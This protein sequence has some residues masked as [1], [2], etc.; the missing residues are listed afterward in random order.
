MKKLTS[1]MT[2]LLALFAF[3][4]VGCS[5]DDDDDDDDATSSSSE[6]SAESTAETEALA[7]F[8]SLEGSYVELFPVIFDSAYYDMWVSYLTPYTG[9]TY[10]DTVYETMV[11]WMTGELYGEEAIEAYSTGTAYWNCSF[12][13]QFAKLTFSYDSLKISA[14]DEDG[15]E[16]FS[17]KYSYY[18]EA[19]D[20]YGKYVF[21][22]ED[23]A[24]EFKYFIFAGDTPESTYHI[25][26]R[27]GSDPQALSEFYTGAYAYWNAAG[28]PED[29]DDELLDNVIKLFADENGEYVMSALGLL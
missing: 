22:T 19:S 3:S 2:I 16:V 5:D 24:G 6:V 4:F 27:W 12:N 14:V 15:N 10:V 1:L 17:H 23:D 8:K 28:F 29:Y 7:L 21:A 25:E 13:S 20:Y 26:F 9:E 18:G 11:S